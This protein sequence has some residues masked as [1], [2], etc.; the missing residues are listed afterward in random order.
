LLRKS[1]TNP[2]QVWTDP[3]GARSLGS[4]ISRQSGQEG[5]K[6]VSSVHR[7]PLVPRKYSWYAFLLETKSTPGP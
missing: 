7:P 2:V 3:K 6:F 5:G 4:Q 1:K